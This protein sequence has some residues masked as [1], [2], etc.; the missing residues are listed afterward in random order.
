MSMRS[1][2]YAPLTRIV[3]VGLMIASFVVQSK[4]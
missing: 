1:E 4:S 2:R 3:F